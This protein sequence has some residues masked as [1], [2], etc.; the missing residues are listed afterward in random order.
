MKAYTEAAF[1]TLIE[2]HLLEH[3]GY[4]R[5][6][7][8]AFDP[9]LALVPA[10]LL[11]FVEATQPRCCRARCSMAERPGCLMAIPLTRWWESCPAPAR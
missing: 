2:E 4:V 3:G 5:G 9:E 6:D 8:A 11:A 7:P 10:D 1:E